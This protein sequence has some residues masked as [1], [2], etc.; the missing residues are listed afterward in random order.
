[1]LQRQIVRKILILM[2][3]TL[4]EVLITLGIIGIVA[5]M[6]IPTLI[7]NYQDSQ[8]HSVITKAIST[9]SQATLLIKNENGGTLVSAFG[10]SP[11]GATGSSQSDGMAQA[12][13][14]KLNVLQFCSFTNRANCFG[15]VGTGNWNDKN[16]SGTNRSNNIHGAGSVLILQDGTGV[17]FDFNSETCNYNAGAF[18]NHCGLIFIDA[19]GTKA[20]N[21][22]G[23][24]IFGIYLTQDAIVP[25]N[26]SNVYGG[27]LC[28]SG[29]WMGWGCTGY[30]LNGQAWQ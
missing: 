14:N 8:T 13:Q 11:S 26:D 30:L 5:A 19:N 22:V 25:M 9:L 7:K 27:G 21:S 10:T 17:S 1:M 2:G 29:S 6:T 20:P 28:F 24:D 15:D 12:Y 23:N 16:R 3:F 4:A 18:M